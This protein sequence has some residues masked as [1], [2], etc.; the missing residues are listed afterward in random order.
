MLK[1]GVT[2]WYILYFAVPSIWI[3]KHCANQKATPYLVFFCYHSHSEGMG[4]IMFSP[5]SVCLSTHGGVPHPT[6]RGIP[7][8]AEKGA[9]HP[10]NGG[11]HHLVDWVITPSSQLGDTPS[12]QQEIT[13]SGQWWGI[14]P[15]DQWRVPPFSW[16]GQGVTPVWLMAGTPYQGFM[17][18]TP[19]QDCMGVPSHLD[20]MGYPPPLKTEQQSKHLLLRS[21][22]RTSLFS[23]ISKTGM[24][25]LLNIVPKQEYLSVKGI[26]SA[27]T[28]I[29]KAFTRYRTF[30][31][32]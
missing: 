32:S 21:S 6:D 7:H 17:E 19:C 2:F 14:P 10:A 28:Q 31:L 12:G 18:I 13:P 9:P 16:W 22:R 25:M 23:W 3:V 30:S 26:P 5:V 4:K 1:E 29:I 20:W 24:L 8:P 27:N 11:Y 15:N